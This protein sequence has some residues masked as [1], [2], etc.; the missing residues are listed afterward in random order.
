[1]KIE[2]SK[3]WLDRLIELAN[4]VKEDYTITEK[5]TYLLGY[6]EGAKE[7]LKSKSDKS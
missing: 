3:E 5:L 2:I 6:I 7:I 4:K 1:M